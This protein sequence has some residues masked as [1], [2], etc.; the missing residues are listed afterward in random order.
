MQNWDVF[1]NNLQ[2]NNDGKRIRHAEQG[3]NNSFSKRFT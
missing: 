2:V 3:K 1:I